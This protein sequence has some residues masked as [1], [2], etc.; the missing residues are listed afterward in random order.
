MK[1]PK[2]WNILAYS[3]LMA[4]IVACSTSNAN[5]INV[6]DVKECTVD[7]D[8]VNFC[9]NSNLKLYNEILKRNRPNFDND[10]YIDNF[11]YNGNYYFFVIELKR[12]KVYTIPV[13]VELLKNVKIIDFKKDS[14]HLCLNGNINQYQNSYRGARVCYQYEN[15]NLKLDSTEALNEVR[16]NNTKGIKTLLLPTASDYFIKCLKIN[17]QNK[18]EKLSSTENH[19]YTLND[20]QRILPDISGILN[21]QKIKKLNLDGFKF[22]PNIGNSQ[23]V[24]GEKYQDTDNGSNT[25]FY[26]LKIKPDIDVKSLGDVYSVDK[27]FNLSYKDSSGNKKNLKLD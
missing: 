20:V 5:V 6:A 22:L 7:F 21:N 27:Q 3:L 25:F 11:K 4:Q 16:E 15:G 18:C 9:K 2:S 13:S 1:F 26:L 12:S 19:V 8:S 17:S 24:I 14:N 23:Y 10:K